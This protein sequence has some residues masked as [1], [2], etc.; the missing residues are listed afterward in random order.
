MSIK[1][2]FIKPDGSVDAKE[3]I[4][5]VALLF[6]IVMSVFMLYFNS[7]RAID[8]AVEHN[9]QKKEDLAAQELEKQEDLL[10]K[11]P[12][13]S[14]AVV[15]DDNEN[16]NNNEN[17]GTTIVNNESMEKTTEV[18]E[19][20][21]D[22]D[23]ENTSFNTIDFELRRLDGSRTTL[24]S[25]R[26]KV[27]FMTFWKPWNAIS[28]QLPEIV[29]TAKEARLAH[30]NTIE[31]IQVFIPDSDN[32][33]A[34]EMIS[35]LSEYDISEIDMFFDDEMKLSKLFAVG[36][37]PITYVFDQKGQVFDYQKG[38]LSADKMRSIAANAIADGGD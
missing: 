26:E 24:A 11:Q 3:L 21:D 6:I 10:E 23:Q 27:V 17:V 36:E 33:S 12:D 35:Q 20:I 38:V 5:K 34:E 16:D 30:D 31:T 15:S 37:C 9:N 8:R 18:T 2:Q 32:R 28:P 14:K 13:D 4:F 19:H 7:Q 22:K 29:L 1:N 25:F